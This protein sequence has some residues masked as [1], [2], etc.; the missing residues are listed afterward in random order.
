MATL[1]HGAKTVREFLEHHGVHYAVT[2]HEET[3]TAA[4]EARA[5]GAEPIGAAKTVM[6]R[7]ASGYAMAVVPASQL[8]DLTKVR[9]V[10]HR[11]EL[12]LATEADLARDFPAFPVGALPPLGPLF[13]ATEVIDSTLLQRG[14]LVCNGGDHTHSIVLDTRDLVQLT[15]PEVGD[16]ATA[17]DTTPAATIPR[18]GGARTMQ[19]FQ[20]VAWQQP[21]QLREVAV[22]EPG[23]GQVLL[24]VGGAGLCHSDLHLMEWE[25]GLMPFEPPFTLGHENAGWVERVGPGVDAVKPGEA[26]A[27]Y[28]PWGCGTCRACRRSS[29]NYCEHAADL[30]V[31]GGGLGLDGGMAEYMLVPSSRLLVPLDGLD[32]RDAAP[33]SDAAL[34]PYHAIKRSL[35]RLTPGSST[36][37]IGV[38]GLGHMAV[39]ILKAV[40]ATQV[41]AVDMSP[42]KLALATAVGADVAIQSGPDAAEA[43]R[44]ATKGRGAD[45]VL[46]LVGSAETIALAAGSAHAESDV[47]IVG[48]A[49]GTFEFSFFSQAY[50]AALTTTYWGS[51][52]ELIEVLDLARAG[53]IGV[54]VERHPLSE[55]ATVY[56]RLREG[57][58]DGRAVVCPHG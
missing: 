19:A 50:E 37:V 46:D 9:A 35:H 2:E 7:D 15:H 30:G 44:E 1:T 33:L 41:I 26:V 17:R 47:T 48:I 40:C 31:M 23:P 45:L 18:T 20:L 38:G 32:P 12:E 5:S 8:L 34:T 55:V 39:Q 3:Y 54:H 36:V 51:A 56:D 49:G 14:K 53:K 27:V 58:I 22:P 11:Q 57:R 28:G 43:I 29:E 16:I 24:K 21:P 6:L 42:E 13:D 25:A 4:S 52:I 10:L